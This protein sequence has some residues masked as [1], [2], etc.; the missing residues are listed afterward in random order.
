MG[1]IG[2]EFWP[3]KTVFEGTRSINI[4]FRSQSENSGDNQDVRVS[5]LKR[6]VSVRGG[7]V[8]QGE[9]A[10]CLE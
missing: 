10:F 5:W 2:K 4:W 8:V 9:E 7:R 1:E 6:S 3:E